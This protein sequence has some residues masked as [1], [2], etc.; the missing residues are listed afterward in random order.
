MI[1]GI[2]IDI[3]DVRRIVRL[4]RLYPLRFPRRILHPTE[5]LT[6]QQ[7]RDKA[8]YLARQFAAK[9]AISKALGCGFRNGCYAGTMIVERD[10]AGRPVAS[11]PA[12][13]ADIELKVSISGEKDYVVAQALAL[14][15]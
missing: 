10:A 5:L 3:V 7:K 13:G 1:H 9:E 8:G 12:A 14:R 15:T 11:V 6:Y 4:L 2:G